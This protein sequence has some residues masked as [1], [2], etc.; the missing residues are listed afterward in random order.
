MSYQF[1]G[2]DK[3]YKI[4]FGNIETETEN[5]L[6]IGEPTTDPGTFSFILESRMVDRRDPTRTIDVVPGRQYSVGFVGYM[7]GKEFGGR[8]AYLP[9][10][11]AH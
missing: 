3:Q 6:E 7:D 5:M 2:K 4:L 10:Q 1:L 9:V 11:G 8:L